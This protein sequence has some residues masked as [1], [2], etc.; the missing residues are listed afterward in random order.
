[1]PVKLNDVVKREIEISTTVP[2]SPGLFCVDSHAGFG[3]VQS[4]SRVVVSSGA[5]GKPVHEL[6]CQ[7]RL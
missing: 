4:K 1:M 6:V 3:Q 2:T 7:G 5:Q